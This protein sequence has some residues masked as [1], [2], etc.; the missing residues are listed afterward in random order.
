MYDKDEINALAVLYTVE[1]FE[2]HFESLLKALE[3][4]IEKIILR[5]PKVQEHLDDIKQEVFIKLLDLQPRYLWLE[6]I[7]NANIPSDYFFFRIR[8]WVRRQAEKIQTMYD[9]YNPLVKSIA[10]LTKKEKKQ[11]RIEMTREDWEQWD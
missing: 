4:M 10:E 6:T 3:P 11:L 5:Y 1:P 8:D 9:M 7:F 2:E